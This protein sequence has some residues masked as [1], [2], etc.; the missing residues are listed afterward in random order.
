MK[1]NWYAVLGF[2]VG[3]VISAYLYAIWWIFFVFIFVALLLSLPVH[4]LFNWR[5]KSATIHAIVGTQLGFLSGGSIAFL[6]NVARWLPGP[7]A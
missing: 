1:E 3:A 2:L 4:V 6:L 5:R 7:A